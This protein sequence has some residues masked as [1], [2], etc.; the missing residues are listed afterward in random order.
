MKT[1]QLT[2]RHKSWYSPVAFQKRSYL[3]G[4]KTL[5][6]NNSWWITYLRRHWSQPLASRF[7]ICQKTYTAG[8]SS[9]K[10]YTLKVRKLRLFL[11]KISSVNVLILVIADSVQTEYCTTFLLSV[12]SCVRPCVTGVTSHI[13]HIYKGINAML[14]IRD[15]ST[16]IFSESKSFWLSF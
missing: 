16:P 2:I 7:E 5:I 3:S 11:L 6:L 14:I 9:Q 10:F 13:S 8:F 12:C 4:G 1:C 15:P